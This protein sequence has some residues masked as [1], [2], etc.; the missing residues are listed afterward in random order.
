MGKTIRAFVLL[1]AFTCPTQAGWIQNDVKQPPPD[2]VQQATPGADMP[3]GGSA[4][5]MEAA[6][7]LLE[8]VLS[9]L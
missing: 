6:L 4:S 8:S 9:L 7:S 3:N 2:A 1:L 5:V